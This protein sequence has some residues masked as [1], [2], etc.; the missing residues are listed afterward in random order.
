V[1]HEFGTKEAIAQACYRA[2][3]LPAHI[4]PM[5]VSK[6]PTLQPSVDK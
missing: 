3:N 5:A 1:C 2:K 6:F 4:G